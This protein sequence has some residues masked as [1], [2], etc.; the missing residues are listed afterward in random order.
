[1]TEQRR[2]GMEIFDQFQPWLGRIL[3]VIWFLGVLRLA[4]KIDAM[5]SKD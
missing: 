1:M 5:A 3:W 2:P 4:Y